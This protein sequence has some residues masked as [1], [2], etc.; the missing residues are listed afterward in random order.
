MG[1]SEGNA[2]YLVD[3][4]ET[5]RKKVMKA[6]TDSGPTAPDSVKPEPIQN[7]FTLLEVVSAPD[8]YTYF[9]E[10]YNRCAIRYGDLKKQLAADIIAFCAPIRERIL[11]YAANTALLDKVAADGAEKA[12]ESATRTLKEVR[13]AIGFRI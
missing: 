9:N 8:V 12:R 6:V 10:Q 7:L 2:I 11:E 4:A 13:R 1:K 5:I 3:D